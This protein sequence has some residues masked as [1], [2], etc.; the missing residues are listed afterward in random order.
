MTLAEKLKAG[1]RGESRDMSP[2]AI[3]RRFDILV[4]LDRTARSLQTSVRLIRQKE[5][6]PDD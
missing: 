1:S 4:E 5:K 2:K 6:K 3:S